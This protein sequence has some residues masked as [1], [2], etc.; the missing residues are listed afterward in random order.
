[1][2]DS[3][4]MPYVERN[5][6]MLVQQL[7]PVMFAMNNRVSISKGSSSFYINMGSHPTTPMV[8][9]FGGKPQGS[10]EVIMEMLEWMVIILVQTQ[11]T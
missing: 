5:S 3:F 10:N 1:M 2:L 6:H 4:L 8:M 7:P 11:P 9:L